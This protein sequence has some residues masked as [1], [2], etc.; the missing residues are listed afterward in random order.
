MS[1]QAAGWRPTPIAGVHRRRTVAHA[2]ARGAFTELWRTS[3]TAPFDDARFVQANLSRSLPRV[4]RGLHVHAH[5]A[6]LWTVL[7]GV[8][9]VALVDLRAALGPAGG[10]PRTTVLPVETGDQL[11][12]P[13]LVAHGFYAHTEL[14]L[15][16][17]VTAEYDGSDEAGFAW[18]DAD[19]A[20]P[21]PD[22]DP[23]LSDRD[24]ANPAL[25]D[26]LARLRA[27]RTRGA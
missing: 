13:R 14:S 24:R 15:C 16:Y 19:A 27:E 5:Q 25:A 3:W 2:D 4:L 23:I 12:I 20:V 21:W 6:D 18:D 1:D 17:L 9:M 26:F 10:P 7:T 11:Y 22:R 8:G